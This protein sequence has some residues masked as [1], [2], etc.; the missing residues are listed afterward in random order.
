MTGNSTVNFLKQLKYN[1]YQLTAQQYRTLKGQAL[2]GDVA[3]AKKGL[4]KL[5]ERG[6]S[7]GGC[8]VDKNH[9]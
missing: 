9:Y 1:R 2:A 4:Q 6:C 5:S 8:K 7:Y 3:G